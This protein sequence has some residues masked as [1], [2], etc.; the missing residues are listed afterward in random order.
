M[1]DNIHARALQLFEAGI[2]NDISQV[3]V[4]LIAVDKKMKDVQSSFIKFENSKAKK[5]AYARFLMDLHR[6]DFDLGFLYTVAE[7]WMSA[8]DVGNEENL[9]TAEKIEYLRGRPRPSRDPDRIDTLVIN[10]AGMEEGYRFFATYKIVRTNGGVPSGL[11]R[12][13][14]EGVPANGFMIRSE[15]EREEMPE[16]TDRAFNLWNVLKIAEPY[17]EK[18]VNFDDLTETLKDEHGIDFSTGKYFP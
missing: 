2:R 8:A 16:T 12:T 4:L 5:I 1:S 14:F 6:S 11:L 17:I 13:A 18:G 15:E 7:A 3:P 10:G 9:S